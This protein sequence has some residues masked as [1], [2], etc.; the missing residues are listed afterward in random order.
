MELARAMQD[1]AVKD[2]GSDI[3]KT[4]GRPPVFFLDICPQN[5][6]QIRETDPVITNKGNPN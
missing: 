2:H 4:D 3:E 1:R 5:D 6:H